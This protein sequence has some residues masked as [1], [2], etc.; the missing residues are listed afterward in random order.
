MNRNVRAAKIRLPG[1][2]FAHIG[3]I[4]GSR[5]PGTEMGSYISIEESNTRNEIFNISMPTY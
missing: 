4:N 5:R 1:E 2:K 3:Q